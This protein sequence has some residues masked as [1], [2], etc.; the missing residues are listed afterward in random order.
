MSD[1]ILWQPDPERIENS[2]MTAFRR[3][4][5]TDEAPVEADYDAFHRW[6]VAN[7]RE[8]WDA[9]VR[10]FQVQA[11]WQGPVSEMGA[12]VVGERF[13]PQARIN[14]AENL[15]AAGNPD[16]TA[17]IEHREDGRRRSLSFRELRHQS[18]ALAG[19]LQQQGVQAGDRVAAFVPN[20]MEAVIGMLATA[21]LGGIWSSCSPDFGLNGVIDRFGQIE[22]KV[23]IAINGY[24][25]NGKLMD[26][27]ERVQAICDEL[28]SLSRLI[29]IDNR[30][31]L[32]WAEDAPGMDW[33]QA[34]RAEPEAHYTRLAFNAP[35]YI[36]YS[37][38]TTGAPKCIVH[39]IGGTLLQHLKE[40]GLHTDVGARDR[41]FYYTTCGWMMWNWLVSSLAL[42][43]TVVLFD[44]SPFS[45]GP[46]VLWDMA[47]REQVRIFGVSAKYYAA[48]ERVGLK[49]RES[50]DLAVLDALLATGSPLTH[51]SFDYLY[52]DVKDNVCV[53]SISGGTDIV[54]CFAL[55]NPTLPVYRGELQC[56]GLGMDVAFAD[57]QGQPLASG[58]GE[59]IC[60]N[61]FPSMPLGFWKDPDNERFHNAYFSRFTGVWA[62]GDYGE[63]VPHPATD[64]T[65]AQTGVI[66]HGRSDAVLN[67]GGVRIGTAEIYR[68]VEKVDEVV[69]SL[70]IGQQW[71]DDVRV[72]LFV[73]LHDEA[74]LDDAL[75]RR[76]RQTIRDNTTPRH[77][78]AK[79]LAVPD[80]PRTLSGKTVE[81]AV[82][83]VVHGEP[84]KNQDAL[85][86]P[87]ALAYFRD[88]PELAE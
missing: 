2:R 14:F 82:R 70:A 47:E 38:G 26:T 30:A 9:L 17:L 53:A 32:P 74:S 22:P 48:C 76:I 57:E 31:D 75:C 71:Q 39:G 56:L 88:R 78:P 68:Q 42:G 84:V 16:D 45:P 55:G 8:F 73:R 27:R 21:Q 5:A 44:G 15:L 29:R 63:L 7:H 12:P 59:L 80:I 85:A 18:Q 19:C 25:Y 79:I 81:L 77:V 54:S 64:T 61:A 4:L 13:F 69:E 50:H 72:V 3:Y 58:K 10:F 35:L 6:T 20:G 40:L 36:L 87:E 33:D 60:R 83:N 34:L 86:N 66:I 41:V 28:P 67:P 24:Q 11:D 43:A 46:S 23:L 37:S 49:P 1:R 65:P 62:H 52:R 51:E